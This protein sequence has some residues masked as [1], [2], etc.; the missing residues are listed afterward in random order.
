LRLRPALELIAALKLRHKRA[1]ELILDM[2]TDDILEGLFGRPEAKLLRATRVE[3]ARPA[4]DD[5]EDR[6]IRFAADAGRDLRACHL[7]EGRDLLADRRRQ[8]GHAQ[9]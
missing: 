7:R 8:A 9:V 3:I 1:P 6:R 5:T 4:R 2:D